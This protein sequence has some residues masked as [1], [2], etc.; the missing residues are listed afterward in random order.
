VRR[1]FKKDV[2]PAIGGLKTTLVTKVDILAILNRVRD[3]G[4]G[5]TANRTLAAIRKAFNWAVSE[6]HLAAS[7]ALGISPRV[8]EQPRSRS[9]TAEEIRFLWNGLFEAKMAPGTKVALKLALVTGQR[10]GEVCGAQKAEVDLGKAEWIIPARRSKSRRE[11]SVP[12]S[13][14]AVKLFREAFALSRDSGYVF[15]SKPRLKSVQRSQPLAS[16]GVAHAMRLALDK[17]GLKKSPATP[18]DLRRTVATHLAGMGIGEGPRQTW[19]RLMRQEK[20]EQSSANYQ[21]TSWFSTTS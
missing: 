3:R 13:P 14:L 5:V 18:H 15:P 9:L 1:I 10:I 6:G 17:L 12:L 16:H 20:D 2:R 19:S 7:P 21:Q 4:A 11:H 8:K